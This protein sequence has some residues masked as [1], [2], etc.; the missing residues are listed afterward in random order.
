LSNATRIGIA[1]PSPQMMHSRLRSAGIESRKPRA[2]SGIAALTNAWSRSLLRRIEMIVP[3]CDSTPSARSD[4][5]WVMRP[6]ADAVLA[7]FLGDAAE[8]AADRRAVGVLLVG[9][10]AVRFLA[11]QQ[12]RPGLLLA[13][14]MAKSN[15]IR[16]STAT[17][18]LVMS[19]GTPE[20]SMIEIGLPALGHAE[21]PADEVGHR[22]A[23]Q[24]AREHELVSRIGS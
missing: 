11:D 18:V 13:P 19:D 23:H 24:H 8:D 22:V 6:S 17:T 7:A 5:R 20:T 15:T 2:P 4:G 9:H 10:V 3:H 21:D 12:D 16:L 1:T 14:Q